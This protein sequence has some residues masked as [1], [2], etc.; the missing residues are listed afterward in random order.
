M[1]RALF[2]LFALTGCSTDNPNYPPPADIPADL[3]ACEQ[4]SDCVIVELGCCDHC[5]G[6]FA[7]SVRA[8]K[9][10]E[11]TDTYSET[12]GANTACTEMA[13]AELLPTC[14]NNVCGSEEAVF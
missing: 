1:S 5:N 2:V 8:D 3:L 9:A 11:V 12:C 10:S 7:L 6:G 4:P 13:C 14:S